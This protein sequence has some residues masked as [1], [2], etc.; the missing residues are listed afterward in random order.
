MPKFNCKKFII[1][2]F[3]EEVN[4]QSKNK[5]WNALNLRTKKFIVRLVNLETNFCFQRLLR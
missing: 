5:F 3:I 4:V 1:T 2:D